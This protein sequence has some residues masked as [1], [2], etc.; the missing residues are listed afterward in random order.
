M[1]RRK[2]LTESLF[3]ASLCQCFPS[4][5]TVHEKRVSSVKGG[6]K[7]QVENLL[8]LTNQKKSSAAA[9]TRQPTPTTQL[10]TSVYSYGEY[11]VLAVLDKVEDICLAAPFDP[12]QTLILYTIYCNPNTLP[13][14]FTN[15]IS[16]SHNST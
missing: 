3:V 14:N 2:P 10:V 9:D 5:L 13:L 12:S 16:R 1:V 15:R 6:K 11:G 4:T 8:L 7:C